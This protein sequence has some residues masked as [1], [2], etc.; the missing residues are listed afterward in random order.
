MD[1][2]ERIIERKMFPAGSVIFRQGSEGRF[3]LIV[4]SGEVEIVRETDGRK[5]VLEVLGSD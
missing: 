3:A 4:Q 1:E 5:I 2:H